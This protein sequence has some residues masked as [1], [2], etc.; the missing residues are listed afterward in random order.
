MLILLRHALQLFENIIGEGNRWIKITVTKACAVD[1]GERR[2]RYGL[3]LFR[4]DR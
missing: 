4:P 3:Y 1:V 2:K